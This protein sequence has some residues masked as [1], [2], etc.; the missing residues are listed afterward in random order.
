M[1]A[2]WWGVLAAG[3]I[4]FVCVVF[5]PS[6]G[7]GFVHI[8]DPSYVTHNPVVQG[9]LTPDGIREAFTA[10]T[11]SL[12]LPLSMLS[13]MLDVSLWGMD[14]RGHHLT[15]VVLHAVNGALLFLLLHAL[16]GA[17]WR[18]LIAALLFAVH[19]LRVESVAWVAERKDLL[20]GCFALLTIDAYRRWVRTPTVGR[21]AGTCV[22]FMLGLLAK[23]M[24]VTLPV[25]LLLLDVWPLG[26]QAVPWS[27][28]LAEKVPLGM[29]AV[30]ASITTLLVVGKTGGMVSLEIL[31][32]AARAMNAVVAY[33]RYLGLFFWPADLA[34]YYPFAV[35]G[36][37]L[38]AAAALLLV[39]VG[40]SAALLWRRAPY[41]GIGLAWFC[42]ALLPVIGL[43]QAGMQSMADRFTYLPAIGLVVAIVWGAADLIASRPRLRTGAALASGLVV[44]A[45]AGT[46]QAQLRHWESSR[47]LFD[48]TL[49]V[50]EENWFVHSAYGDA[51]LDEGDL[52]GAALQYEA[53]LSIEPRM[54]TTQHNLGAIRSDEGDLAASVQHFVEA[55]RL[56]P[57]RENSR[58]SLA[59][60]L[61][62]QGH[63]PAVAERAVEILGDGVPRAMRDRRRPAG[64]AYYGLMM[65]QL[66]RAHSDTVGRCREEA[67][68]GPVFDLFLTVGPNGVVT[69]A[70]TSP[71]TRLGECIAGA[72]GGAELPGPPFAPFHA[73]LTM[74]LGG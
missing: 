10:E 52:A 68:A 65:G 37:V 3:L 24:I 49:S 7:G 33:A 6:I 63:A 67:G 9:G 74:R 22:L 39:A 40:A 43:V 56:E 71:P 35:P 34:V 44:L 14:P 38:V 15:N 18:S 70:A 2:K 51:L 12:W 59:A 13:H 55:L 28:R 54:A 21:Y 30:G 61:R 42:I 53:A 19:P 50:T 25:L 5:A 20:S 73:R 27:R 66:M 4:G 47:T 36:A 29:L 16:T 48:H 11:A 45:L 64:E 1:D 62:A 23:P 26:R 72:L 58:A 69:E 8:D 32:A 31:P 41:L 57:E 46:T 60:T 17:P